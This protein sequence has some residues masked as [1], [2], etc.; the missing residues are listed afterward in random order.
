MIEVPEAFAASTVAR[1]GP[2]GERWLNSLPSLVAELCERW[3]LRV[4]GAPMHG[5]VAVVVPVVRRDVDLVLKVS[6]I[7]QSSE[8]ESVA[9]RAW[10][11]HGAVRMLESRAESGALLLE[12][13]T[14]D[15]SLEAVPADDAARVAGALLRRL[16][17]PAPVVLRTVR[18]EVSDFLAKAERDWRR[19]A[20]PFS[21][22]LLWHVREV[23]ESL[24]ESRSGLIVNQDLHYGNVLAGVREPWLVIDPKPLS[25]LTEFGAAPLLWTRFDELEDGAAF[26]RRLNILVESAEMD[27]ELTKRC[28]LVRVV[29]YW[30]WALSEG[31]TADPEKCRRLQVWLAP[32]LAS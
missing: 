15:R 32:T 22:D 19:F 3:D 7:D 23:G 10:D 9:L 30:L 20:R 6:W 8:H 26:E 24:L 31:L 29:D 17:V 28:T 25:G 12:R 2:S 1:E 27:L 14:A 11:G 4:S 5:Y 18:D 13:L 16:A 21:R